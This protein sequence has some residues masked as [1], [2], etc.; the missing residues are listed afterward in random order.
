MVGRHDGAAFYTIGQRKGMGI[1]GAGDAWF[2]VGKDMQRN[3]VMVEQGSIRP[4]T[5]SSLK[6]VDLSFVSG[7]TPELPLKCTAKIRYRQADQA[8]TLLSIE[9]GK[10]HVVFDEPQRAI[11]PW[12]SIVFYQGD[13]CLGGGF[14]HG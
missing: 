10:A 11:T 14:I 8:C 5:G 7:E 9:G 13:V 1:G 6:A 2:V 3:L 4:S 12:Q